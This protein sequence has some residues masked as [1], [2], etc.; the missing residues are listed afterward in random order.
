MLLQKMTGLDDP[1][2][3][4]ALVFAC[5]LAVFWVLDI[6]RI[7]NFASWFGSDSEGG[8]SDFGDGGSGDD[9]E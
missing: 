1:Y 4:F 9:C 8:E 6:Y 3:A 5:I 2:M 7:V